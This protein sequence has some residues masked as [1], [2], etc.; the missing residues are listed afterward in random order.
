MTS[1]RAGPVPYSEWLTGL[2]EDLFVLAPT[3][4]PPPGSYAEVRTFDD[5]EV[6]PS[7]QDAAR[8]LF[9]RDGYRVIVAKAECDLV[10]AGELR[11]ALGLPGQSHASAVAYRDKTVMKGFV[12]HAGMVTP[13]FRALAR[14]DDLRGFV[15][16]HGCPVVVK[17]VDGSGSIGVRVLHGAEDVRRFLAA[18]LPAGFEVEELVR[19]ALFHVDG[20]VL[21]GE[22]TAVVA[23]RCV[24]P[25]GSVVIKSDRPH[26]S[27][28]LDPASDLAGRLCDLARRIVAALPSPDTFSFHAEVFHTPEDELVFCEVASR[29]GGAMISDMLRLGR[30]L[31]LDRAWVQAQCGLTPDAGALGAGSDGDGGLT[32]RI[33]FPRL[34]G[35]L[36]SLPAAAPPWVERYK[37]A[38]HPGDRFVGPSYRER[39]VGDFVAGCIVRGRTEAEVR[40][41]LDAT[42]EWF[43][44][45][46]RWDRA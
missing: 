35:T 28:L 20:L 25:E 27:H 39:K 13:R 26:G 34:R 44:S 15:A 16:E 11:D 10:R 36:R 21:D 2:D 5:Y 24:P 19:G 37:R 22:T 6:N 30:G 32:G 45:G 40:D 43:A 41:H 31:D 4:A 1:P 18:G 8:E 42:A 46:A 14:P 33:L 3:G 23:S 9:D 17:P 7:V 12:R 38:A 29:T